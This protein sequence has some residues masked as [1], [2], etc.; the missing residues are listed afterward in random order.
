MDSLQ[1]LSDVKGAEHSILQI[2]EDRICGSLICVDATQM[3]CT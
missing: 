3:V 1:S 2:V